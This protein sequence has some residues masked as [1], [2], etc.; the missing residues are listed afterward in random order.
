MRR[1]YRIALIIAAVVV[2]LV[3]SGLLARAL[4]V[5]G[6]E[7]DAI[8][9]LVKAEARGDGS[10][11]VALIEGCSASPTCRAAGHR[12]RDALAPSRHRVDPP[13]ESV[14]ELLAGV[15]ARHRAGGVV[16]GQLDR[17]CPVR[18]RAP[19]GQRSVRLPRPAAD[20]QPQDRERRRLPRPVRRRHGGRLGP[21]GPRATGPRDR[22]R[23]T[24]AACAVAGGP[25]RETAAARGSGA[26]HANGPVR[27]DGSATARRH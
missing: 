19:R 9:S 5:G 27:A 3:I 2:F 21:P 8:T 23:A 1:S 20:R 14:H 11:V 12:A 24:G 22:G 18:P 6:A 13:A 7:S 4:S 16:R 26:G 25:A 17:S 15:D 10:A